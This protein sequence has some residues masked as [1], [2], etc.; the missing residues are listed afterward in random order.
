[1]LAH[2][3]VASVPEAEEEDAAIADDHHH[4]AQY[5]EDDVVLRN[6][7]SNY[8]VEIQISRF[9]MFIKIVARTIFL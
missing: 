6:V 7:F 1:M 9:L 5:V 4:H 2:G 3:V 8:L